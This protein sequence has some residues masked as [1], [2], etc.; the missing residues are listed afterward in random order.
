MNIFKSIKLQLQNS[1]LVIGISILIALLILLFIYLF[2]VLGHI[3]L[4]N[5]T[6]D[7]CAVTGAP[8]YNGLLSQLGLFVWVASASICFF[9]GY[10][11]RK[12][13]KI[14]SFL[15]FSGFLS[16][17]LGLDDAFLLH[18]YFFPEIIAIPEKIVF[19]VYFLIFIYYIIKYFNTILKTDFIIL[20]LAFMMLGGSGFIDFFIYSSFTLIE[21]GP[22]FIGIV[23]WLV[24]FIRVG[25]AATELKLEEKNK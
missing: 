7:T 1:Y 19:L 21:D 18:E 3:P 8:F 17:G 12:N 13:K 15:I 11:N 23:A 24:Y 14:K 16:L 10:F 6:K 20:G 2:S 5:L 9:C 4:G 25:I 22:K